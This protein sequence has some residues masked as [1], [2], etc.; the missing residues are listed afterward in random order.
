MAFSRS[1]SAAL[2]VLPALLFG[3][4][5]APSLGDI[6]RQNRAVHSCD[7]SQNKHVLENEDVETHHGPI[8]E[9]SLGTV[10]NSPQIIAAIFAYAKNHSD[11]DTEQVVHEWYDNEVALERAAVQHRVTITQDRLTPG[12]TSALDQERSYDDYRQYQERQSGNIER[13][14]SDLKL[15]GDYDLV[16]SR[17]STR[18]KEVKMGILM[19]SR[20]NT[21]WFDTDYPINYAVPMPRRA[22]T[23]NYNPY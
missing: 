21:A 5:E 23:S 11:Q 1:C 10:S 12:S 2:L 3:Q 17:V 16:I 18:L 4:S 6:A 19:N 13:D 22:Q 9:I 8:P 14:V 20:F 7:T 15:L